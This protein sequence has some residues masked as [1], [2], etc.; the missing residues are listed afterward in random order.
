MYYAAL[1]SVVPKDTAKC[2]LK[3]NIIFDTTEASAAYLTP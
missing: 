2:I 3:K 1:A